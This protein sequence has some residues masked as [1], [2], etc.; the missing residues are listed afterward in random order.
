M[1]EF[2]P[3][4]FDASSNAWKA[5]KVR[6]GQASYRYTKTAFPKDPDEPPKPKRSFVNE[7]EVKRRQRLEEEAPLPTR[8]SPRLLHQHRAQ[9]YSVDTT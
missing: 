2:T 9:T 5:N 8:K 7:K 3:E 4:A 6:Y 1:S